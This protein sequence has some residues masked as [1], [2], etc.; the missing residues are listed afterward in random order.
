M[1]TQTMLDI[2]A[3]QNLHEQLLLNLYATVFAGDALS[4]DALMQE[5]ADGLAADSK[6]AE[7]MGY[8]FKEDLLVAIAVQPNRFK[9]RTRAR[10]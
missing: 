6:T 1:S 2:Q 3:R 7:P 8:E 10:L 4:F 5:M 9:T